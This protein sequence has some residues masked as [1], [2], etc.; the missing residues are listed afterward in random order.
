MRWGGDLCL[1]PQYAHPTS[2]LMRVI[3]PSAVK[4]PFQTSASAI[5]AFISSKAA[6]PTRP[7]ASPCSFR[8]TS[9]RSDFMTES[10]L[11]RLAFQES[12]VVAQEALDCCR[13]F[14]E[15]SIARVVFSSCFLESANCVNPNGLLVVRHRAAGDG[16]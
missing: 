7:V 3:L 4:P 10:R 15:C 11:T 2:T 6:Y 12:L 14:R 13:L 1:A 5:R 9:S 8:T 16:A